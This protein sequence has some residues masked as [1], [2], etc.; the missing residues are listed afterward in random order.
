MQYSIKKKGKYL[1]YVSIDSC[2]PCH[3]KASRRS[4]IDYSRLA[5]STCF[6]CSRQ[7]NY[8][9]STRDDLICRYRRR[10]NHCIAG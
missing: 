4:S 1:T 2:H 8:A 5:I 7:V 3:H 6:R 9:I 10:I